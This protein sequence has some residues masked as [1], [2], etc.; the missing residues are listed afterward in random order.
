M[1]YTENPIY[2]TIAGWFSVFI[3]FG[4]STIPSDESYNEDIL[5]FWAKHIY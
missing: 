2:D 5:N 4:G 3:Y 1:G